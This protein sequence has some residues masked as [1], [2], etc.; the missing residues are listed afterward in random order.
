MRNWTVLFRILVEKSIFFVKHLDTFG[1]VTFLRSGFF[2]LVWDPF[3]LIWIA[4]SEMVWGS[5]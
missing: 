1:I 4:L 5:I 2:K 3:H